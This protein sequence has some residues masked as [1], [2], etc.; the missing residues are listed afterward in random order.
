MA[1]RRP[2]AQ[3]AFGE[4]M[5]RMRKSLGRRID[6]LAKWFLRFKL[7]S[8]PARTIANSSYAWSFISRTDRIRANRLRDRLKRG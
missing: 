4:R 7:I 1:R 5:G 2:L 6:G 8:V 3:S